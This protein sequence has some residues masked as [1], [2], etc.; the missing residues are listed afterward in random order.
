[1]DILG[2]AL[3]P[4]LAD[5]DVNA[6]QALSDRPLRSA[7]EALYHRLLRESFPRPELILANVARWTDNRHV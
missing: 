7:E 6:E 1:V 2:A 5:L 3:A 4:L